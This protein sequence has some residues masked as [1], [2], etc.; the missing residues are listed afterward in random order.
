MVGGNCLFSCVFSHYE[1]V[2]CVA[3]LSCRFL[4]EYSAQGVLFA[5]LA[6]FHSNPQSTTAVC[7][8]TVAVELNIIYPKFTS[9]CFV[10]VIFTLSSN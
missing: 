3:M 10:L 4:K 7:V 8:C 5:K 9:D 1:N 2:L 6:L